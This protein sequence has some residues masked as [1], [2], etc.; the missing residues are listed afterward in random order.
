[1]SASSTF[2][3]HAKVRA[4]DCDASSI[5]QIREAFADH[6]AQQEKLYLAKI[7]RWKADFSKLLDAEADR[8]ASFRVSMQME[9][10]RLCQIAGAR[11]GQIQDIVDAL[12]DHLQVRRCDD[13]D[14][15]SNMFV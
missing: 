8:F 13:V 15:P 9:C 5:S 4:P 10:D 1:V 7:T 2:I 11:Q 14:L 3:A 12:P 6:L